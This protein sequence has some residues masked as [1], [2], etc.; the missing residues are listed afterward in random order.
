MT[1]WTRNLD[2]VLVYFR[3]QRL[4]GAT[5]AVGLGKYS[6]PWKAMVYSPPALIGVFASEG[7]AADA[8]RDYWRE[9]GHT[10]GTSS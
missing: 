8:V 4:I 2:G 7:E 9:H 6:C 1:R 5:Y 3:D 10:S